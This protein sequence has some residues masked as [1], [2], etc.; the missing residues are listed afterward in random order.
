MAINDQLR[1]MLM[2]PLSHVKRQMARRCGTA[3]ARCRASVRDAGPASS[4]R[5]A[6][7]PRRQPGG[8]IT[9]I[10]CLSRWLLRLD[11]TRHDRGW[12]DWA[13]YWTSPALYLSTSLSGSSPPPPA[14]G[15]GSPPAA[16]P[17]SSHSRRRPTGQRSRLT[18]H[19]TVS[20]RF[21]ILVTVSLD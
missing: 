2:R 12:S 21:S 9:C 20:S 16:R 15:T 5:G 19:L 8:V 6:A 13:A 11:P 7:V 14:G 4:R 10:A 18:D 3:P 17:D 1:C